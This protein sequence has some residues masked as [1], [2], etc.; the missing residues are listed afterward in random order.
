M[1]EK[2][3]ARKLWT[4]LLV[5]LLIAS[6]LGLRAQSGENIGSSQQS[7]RGGTVI[8]GYPGVVEFRTGNVGNSCTGS[9][10]A[11]NVILAAAHC[12]R[13]ANFS[14]SSGWG[15]FRIRY[16]HPVRGRVKLYIGGA[17][18]YVPDSYNGTGS[19]GPGEANDDIG[20]IRIP[21]QTS[22]TGSTIPGRFDGTDYRDY[23][24]IYADNKATLMGKYLDAFGA[25]KFR[26][27]EE[28]NDNKL[29]THRFEVENVENNHIVI[30]NRTLVTTCKGDSGGPLMYTVTTP[31]G[32]IPTIT[33]VLSQQEVE[34]LI[35]GEDCA[36]NDPP[37]D[38][39]SYSRTNWNKLEILTKRAGLTCRLMR[40]EANKKYRRCFSVPFVNDVVAE[41][42][43]RKMAVAI[44]TGSIF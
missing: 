2:P 7:L 43:E 18:W 22:H 21:G 44:V 34:H 4:P 25:G 12:F 1:R 35:E 11:P 8:T 28:N 40:G 5:L 3:F 20:L 23:L 36:N 13:G 27:A 17:T 15:S 33:G 6:P 30:D 16:H 10:I 14:R 9:M 38:D 26:Y 31:T 29:R 37:W 42:F 19:G 32:G 39:S 24:R 41:R